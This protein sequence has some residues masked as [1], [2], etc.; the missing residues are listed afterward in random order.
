MISCVSPTDLIT[1]IAYGQEEKFLAVLHIGGQFLDVGPPMPHL[2]TVLG[3][4]HGNGNAWWLE[5][6]RTVARLLLHCESLFWRRKR[7]KANGRRD[8][9][10]I[11]RRSHACGFLCEI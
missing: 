2:A 6:R 10:F 3:T 4:C 8:E 7:V 5:S 1:L 9:V 11:R